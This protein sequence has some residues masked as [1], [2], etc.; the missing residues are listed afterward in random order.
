MREA[1][2]RVKIVDERAR[3]DKNP[4]E[5][6]DS[7]K[8][9]QEKLQQ[10]FTSARSFLDSVQIDHEPK[11]KISQV[12]ADLNVDGLREDIVTNRAAKALSALKGRDRVSAEDTAIVIPNCLRHRLQKDLWESI[13]SGLLVI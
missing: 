2:L 9:E 11:V 6:R 13:D 3:F 1:E 5:F 7:Y 8:A 12:C 4:I 10:Q